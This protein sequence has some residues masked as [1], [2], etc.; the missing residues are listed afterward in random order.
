[1]SL[2]VESAPR[3][4]VPPRHLAATITALAVLRAGWAVAGV[5][6]F[7]CLFVWVSL[8]ID[9]GYAPIAGIP[10][11][12]ALATSASLVFLVH[13]PSSRRGVVFLSV[14]TVSTFAWVWG[15]LF[16]DP[17]LNLSGLFLVNR[18]TVV[19]LLVGAVGSRLIYGIMWCVAGWTLG[20]FAT[21]AAQS[22][23]GIGWRLGYGPTMS[24]L[25]YVI[26]IVLFVGIRRSQQRFSS[27]FSV[28]HI[29]PGRITGQREL[30]ER[31]VVLLH[32]TVLNDL[33]AIIHGK[34]ELDERTRSR[35][36]RDIETVTEARIE[37]ET[38][39][40]D[41]AHWLQRELLTTI[42]DFQW[43]GLRVDITGDSGIPSHT[44]PRVAEAIA[45]AIRGSLE[46][47]VKHSSSESAELFVDSSDTELTVM[48]VDHGVGFNVDAV[49]KERLGI[50]HSI[51]QR[52]E[53]LGGSVKIWSAEG[54][55]TSV[56][57]VV[58]LASDHE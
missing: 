13:R 47:I 38:V 26:I 16:V 41:V 54:V 52:I 56:V 10:V 15:V 44:S 17:Q 35:F 37:P 30:E 9:R 11:V 22:A 55:G 24:L 43:R 20:S 42:S 50:R 46:N 6:L 19:L 29:E 49:S 45:G 33:G 3:P 18:M 40:S 53:D 14:G 48:I 23:L 34:D 39:H 1:M 31:A 25:V 36:R 32:D 2:L 57:I 27:D 51:M 12:A 4:A 8:W 5:Y 58:P 21:V 28:V 7:V